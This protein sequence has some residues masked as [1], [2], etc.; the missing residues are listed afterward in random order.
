VVDDTGH[1][2]PPGSPG[3]VVVRG[4]VVMKGYWS[5]P[6][7]TTSTVRNGWLHTG[8]IGYMD[9]RGYLYLVDRKKDLIISGGANVYPREVE[10][11]L[12]EHPSVSEAVVFGIPDPE[13]G[14]AVKAVI[15]PRTL[16][17]HPSKDELAAFCRER[18]A[19]YKIPRRIVF[20]SEIPKSAYGKV[21]RRQVKERFQE[22]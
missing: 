4:D 14:E 22:G 21:L 15:V 8:D 9:D 3:E 5:D 12:M 10:E 7:A 13:W 18:I 1:E 19:G 16:D 20:V 17:S 2:V 6:E 11:A